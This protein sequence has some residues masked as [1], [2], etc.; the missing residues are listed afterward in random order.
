MIQCRKGEIILNLLDIAL[1]LIMIFIA[2]VGASRGF[3]KSLSGVFAYIVS[4]FAAKIAALPAA[5]SIYGGRIREKVL[6][7]LS[8]IFPSG[9][10]QGEIGAAVDKTADSLPQ[11]IGAALKYFTPSMIS[12]SDSVLTVSEMEASYISPV[13]IKVLTW[14]AAAVIFILCALLLRVIFGAIDKMLFHRKNPG[15]LS[16]VNKFFGF[17]L[18][19]VKGAASVLA[20]CLLMNLIC[21][22]L[23]SGGFADSVSNSAICVFVS[24]IF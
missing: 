23:G 8:E 19:A 22:L 2:C 7:S 13:L 9:S 3:F 18:G 1:I 12:G 4:A 6:L 21:P 16:W 10:V 15:L 5:E 14:A 17:I 11:Y 20:I 24:Q